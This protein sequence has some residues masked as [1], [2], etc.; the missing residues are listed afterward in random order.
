MLFFLILL[1]GG[2][3]WVVRDREARREETA[4]QARESLTRARQWVGENK[5]ALAR[6]ELAA[7]RGRMGSDR[8]ALGGLVEEIE[9]L[10]AELG[11]LERFLD[12]VEQAHEAEFPQP[13]RW[14]SRPTPAAATAA[15][16]R[17]ASEP[18]ARAGQ[19]RSLSCSRP[20]PATESWSGDDWI[21]RLEGSLLEP[22]QVARVRRTAYEE[23]LW[24]ADD[25]ARR[26]EDHRSGQE[27]VSAGGRPGGLAYLRQAEAAAVRPP[28]STRFVPRCSKGAGTASGSAAGRGSL[29]GDTPATIALDHYLLAGA[30]Y[31][32]RNKA[33]A[34]QQYEAALRVEPTHYWSLLGLG[35]LPEQAGRPTAGLRLGGGSLHRLHPEAAGPRECLPGAGL[36]LLPAGA[37]PVEA[38]AD[39]RERSSPTR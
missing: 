24:L 27:D 23:L 31:D 8:A 16:S 4:Q 20:C 36:R 1:G 5:L 14:L 29:P 34:V 35:D 30:A 28:P 17:Q 12:L 15:A 38:D 13:W 22:D 32:A 37:V 6:Q 18:G 7:A 19:G 21:A 26:G 9:A 10:D 39:V 25:V 33:E 2:V 3:G 11:K